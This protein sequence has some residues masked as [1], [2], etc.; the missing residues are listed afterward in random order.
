MGKVNLYYGRPRIFIMGARK[1]KPKQRLQLPV[2]C[3]STLK[4]G[5][6]GLSWKVLLHKCV[7]LT[8]PK[9]KPQSLVP[10]TSLGT[11]ELILEL[12]SVNG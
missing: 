3:L 7:P 8:L 5:V 9:Y 6:I 12:N 2:F 4:A 11:Q 1:Q 10:P